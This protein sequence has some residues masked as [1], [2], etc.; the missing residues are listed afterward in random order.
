MIYIRASI[1]FSFIPT[2][3]SISSTANCISCAVF[4]LYL[5]GCFTEMCPQYALSMWLLLQRIIKPPPRS[6]FDAASLNLFPLF[7]LLTPNQSLLSLCNS[8]CMD[9]A[10]ACTN[11]TFLVFRVTVYQRQN[12]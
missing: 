5:F 3:I 12:S 2:G 8:N 1:H 10:F 7:I 6:L 4:R 9:C 11:D